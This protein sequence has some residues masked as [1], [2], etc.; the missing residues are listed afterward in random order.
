VLY[1]KAMQARPK[2]EADRDAAWPLLDE[3]RQ[4]WLRGAILDFYGADHAWSRWLEERGTA[5]APEA[6]E[7]P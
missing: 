5:S 2:D 1:H 4:T 3:D 6:S 7:E